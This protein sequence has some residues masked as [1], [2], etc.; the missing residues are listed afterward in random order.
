MTLSGL[1]PLPCLPVLRAP[2]IVHTLVMFLLASLL[3]PPNCTLFPYTTLF[4]SSSAIRS[5]GCSSPG[6]W[7]SG[8]CRSKIGRARVGKECRSRWG[9]YDLK[10][11]LLVLGWL[12]GESVADKEKHTVEYLAHEL[13]SLNA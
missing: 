1:Q 5:S 6:R 8:R 4:R 13:P 2:A 3:Q 12:G 7:T 10:K 11:K 9:A